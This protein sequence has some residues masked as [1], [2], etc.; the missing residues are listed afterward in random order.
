M[1]H[2]AIPQLSQ[3][4]RRLTARHGDPSSDHD[5]LQRFVHC[6]DER[7]FAALVERHATMVL[8]L[9]RSILHNGH[10]AEDIF[11]AAFLV[12]ARKA[13]SLRKGESVGSYLYSVAT[14]LARKARLRDDKRQ[15][16][17]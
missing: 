3:Y 10:D 2:A 4:L 6:R 15:R 13:A 17:E 5:L 8:G 11:Q 7:A 14:R 16:R 1:G 9:C 12:L